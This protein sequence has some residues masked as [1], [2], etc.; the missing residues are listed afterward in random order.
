MQ[1]QVGHYY[2][3]SSARVT[4]Y[5]YQLELWPGYIT[6]I[7]QHENELLLCTK[8]THKVMRQDTVYTLLV[9]YYDADPCNYE[10]NMCKI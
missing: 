8:I 2:Y 4:L 6:S 3:D 1:F 10:V 5:N 9:E 7:R